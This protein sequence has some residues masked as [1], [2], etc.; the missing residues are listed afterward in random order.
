IVNSFMRRFDDSWVDHVSF[1]DYANITNPPARS[2]PAFNVDATLNFPPGQSYAQRA[3][4]LYR[5][6]ATAIDVPM[7]P[8]TQQSHWDA[9]AAAVARGVPVRLISEPT[10][11]RNPKRLWDAWNVDRMWKAGVK[12]RMRAHAGLNHQK[13]VILHGLHTVIFGSSNWT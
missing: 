2:Y 12:I 3:I 4:A 6:E 13:S 1:A 7:Y 5:Q 9:M 8:I 11:Y 10:E